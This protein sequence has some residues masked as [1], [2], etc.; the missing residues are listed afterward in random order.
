[1]SG[2]WR[3]WLPL[4]RGIFGESEKELFPGLVAPLL[5][6]VALYGAARGRP[7]TNRYVWAY[8]VV[9]LAGF[10]LSLG[11][12]VRVWG[13][14]LTRHGP[15]D[16]LRQ[17]VPGMGGMRTPSRFVVVVI[18]GLSVLA[19]VGALR[20]LRLVSP[21]LRPIATA[22][23]LAGVVADGWAVPIPV[24]RYSPR[25]RPEDRAVA[26]WLRDAPPGAVLHLPVNTAQ[27]QE[28]NYQYATLFHPHPLVNGFTGWDSPLQQMLR[29]PRSPMYDYVR[30]PAT[31]TMLRALG[32]KYVVVH[33]GDYNVTQLADGELT[34]TLAGFRQSG[35]VLEERRLLEVHAFELAPM[36]E[37]RGALP[38]L[39]PI[40]SQEFRVEVSQQPERAGFLVDGDND[41][42]WIGLQDGGSAI[43]A[44]FNAP[45]DV[46]RVEL[47][48]AERSLWDF[49]RELQIEVEDAAGR[50]R[51]VYR[52]PPYQE[53]AAAFLRDRSY[54]SI[55]I[56]LPAN[57]TVVLRMRDVATYD[58]WWSVHELRL[59]A[60]R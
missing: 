25:G 40:S 16:W 26:D 54:P 10:V 27:F 13:V 7:R 12:L 22:V 49:P 19:G 52:A 1:V 6:G 39:R 41:S 45:R 55:W 38:A 9:G 48:L 31:V 56:D 11:P 50:V 17:I 58:T 47:Q 32:V 34:A 3:R 29:H 2:I 24:V 14:V 30:Y 4:P 37:P 18:A 20:V 35:Q 36:A 60:R 43:A 15:Y 33:P 59:W 51:T 28:L 42:R 53:F 21:R 23:L 44:R 57:E 8:A 46:A 5:A